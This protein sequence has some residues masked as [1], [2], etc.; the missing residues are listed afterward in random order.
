MPN[1]FAVT[2]PTVGQAILSVYHVPVCTELR[3]FYK[4]FYRMY[5]EVCK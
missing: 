2:Q 3:I 1:D 4:V 5:C